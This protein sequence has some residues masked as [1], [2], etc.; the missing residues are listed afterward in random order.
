MATLRDA[1]V[2]RPADSPTDWE[3]GAEAAEKRGMNRLAERL[4]QKAQA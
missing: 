4:R 1:G 2:K 3:G